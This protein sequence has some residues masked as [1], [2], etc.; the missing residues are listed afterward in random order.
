[1]I[2]LLWMYKQVRSL[3]SKHVIAVGAGR[4]HTA[5]CTD[6]EVYT[7]GKNLGQLGYEKTSETQVAPH[8]VSW[9]ISGRLAVAGC[10]IRVSLKIIPA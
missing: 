4:Y 6:S 10:K 1:M 3:K 8:A 2:F 5:M 9:I 7:V